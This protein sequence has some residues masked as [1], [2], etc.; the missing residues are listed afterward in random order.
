MSP[1]MESRLLIH[2]ANGPFGMRRWMYASVILPLSISGNLSI[3]EE[4]IRVLQ[5]GG[6][7]CIRT[8]NAF[9]YRSIAARILPH[10]F[11]RSLLKRPQPNRLSEDVFPVRYHCSMMPQLRRAI[12]RHEFRMAA[13]YAIEPAPAYLRGSELLFRIDV[14]CRTVAP[15]M[16]RRTMLAFVTI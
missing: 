16:L 1:L 7:L 13:V 15:Q 11:T 10:E 8:S 12:R 14:L 5:N 9:H 2:W 4:A 3:F 6:Y